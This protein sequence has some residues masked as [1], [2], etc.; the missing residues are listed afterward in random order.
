[1]SSEEERLNIMQAVA[2]LERLIR[3]STDPTQ[4]ADCTRQIVGWPQRL[5]EVEWRLPCSADR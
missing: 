2:H 3:A 1:M 5:T 4:V